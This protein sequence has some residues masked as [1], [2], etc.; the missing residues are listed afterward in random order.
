MEN[1]EKRRR[2][3]I[4]QSTFQ[5]YSVVLLPGCRVR[6]REASGSW[7]LVVRGCDYLAESLESFSC[8]PVIVVRTLPPEVDAV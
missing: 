3:D 7:L 8:F 1:A 2:A 5:G 4:M 6:R